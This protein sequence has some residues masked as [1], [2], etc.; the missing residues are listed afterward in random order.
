MMKESIPYII[1][2]LG[3]LF[4]NRA[5][6]TVIGYDPTWTVEL[7][8]NVQLTA[9]LSQVQS[10]LIWLLMALSTGH[11]SLQIHWIVD[12]FRPPPIHHYY[13]G[14]GLS[15]KTPFSLI[16]ALLIV[17]YEF[18]MFAMI[19][20]VYA[21]GS[22][23]FV[24][25]IIFLPTFGL[26]VNTLHQYHLFK[27][28][29]NCL[30]DIYFNQ[31]D[32][33]VAL[34]RAGIGLNSIMVIHLICMAVTNWNHGGVFDFKYEKFIVV[35]LGSTELGY[36]IWAIYNYYNLLMIHQRPNVRHEAPI[37][38]EDYNPHSTDM[39]VVRQPFNM[40]NTRATPNGYMT[41]PLQATPR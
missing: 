28:Q 37:I 11:I 31:R 40:N 32:N 9:R 30:R 3:C 25:L 1:G 5:A 6:N 34:I 12:V 23:F 27:N 35:L 26:V 17:L 10:V 13:Y 22:A 41:T 24:Q 29:P 19:Y 38:E 18:W 15:W 21:I 14:L 36:R 33:F 8:A 16:V 4:M 39:T 2:F 7:P 20:E